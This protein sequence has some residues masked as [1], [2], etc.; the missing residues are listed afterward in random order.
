[1]VSVVVWVN[2][3]LLLDAVVVEVAVKVFQRYKVQAV[4]GVL[5]VVRGW[6]VVVVY[7]LQVFVHE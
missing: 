3:Q 6:L 5:V 4:E 1:V 7:V 2:V